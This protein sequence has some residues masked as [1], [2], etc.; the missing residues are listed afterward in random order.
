MFLAIG[1]APRLGCVALLA[2]QRDLPASLPPATRLETR[3]CR[4]RGCT[5]SRPPPASV[6]AGACCPR[7][8]L[9]RGWAGVPARGLPRRPLPL[10]LGARSGSTPRPTGVAAGREGPPPPPPPPAPRP[11]C[12][13]GRGPPVPPGNYFNAGRSVAGCPPLVATD[14]WRRTLWQPSGISPDG[15][16][17]GQAGHQGPFNEFIS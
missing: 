12:A 11:R 7:L 3:S 13:R 5:E 4:D 15:P 6:R 10:R 2:A 17:G 9:A 14:A 1:L 16:R 8:R